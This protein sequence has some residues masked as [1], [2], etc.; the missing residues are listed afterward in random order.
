MASNYN[1]E[2][3]PEFAE[4]INSAKT[5]LSEVTIGEYGFFQFYKE[6]GKEYSLN[7]SNLNPPIKL[8]HESKKDFKG[9]Y[10][11]SDDGAVQYVGISKNVLLRI[12]QHFVSN[13]HYSASLVYLMALK[14]YEDK[15]RAKSKNEKY[16]YK[17]LRKDLPNFDNFRKKQQE[18]MRDRWRISF[19]PQGDSFHL[20]VLEAY[21]AC[22][23]K[24]KWN[25]FRTH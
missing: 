13:S 18:L 7:L 1:N 23:L 5:K 4:I 6:N 22:E 9:L 25:S 17:G 8:D 19:I 12:K 3:I 20:H 11:L 15:E 16:K 21:A 14:E 24:A 2:T 10:I